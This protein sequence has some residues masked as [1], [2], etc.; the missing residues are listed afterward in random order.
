MAKFKLS[1]FLVR[2]RVIF[3]LAAVAI[4]IASI[5]MIPRTNI[6][7]D[8]TRYLPDDSQMKHGIDKMSEEFGDASL[9]SGMVRVMFKSLPDSTRTSIKDEL[10]DIEGVANVI[11]IEGSDEYNRDEM[12]L[13]ELL[14]NSKRSQHE[15]AD[16]ISSRYGDLVIVETSE[17]DTTA[18]IG[19]MLIAFALLLTVLLIMCESWLEPPIFLAAIGVAVAINMGTNALLE[20]VSATTNSIAAILQLVLSIDYS[21]ILMNRYRQE[22]TSGKGKI[23]AMSA[24]LNKASS[25]I[26]SSAFTTIVGLLALVFMKLKIGADMGIVLAKGV[27]CSLVAIFTVLPTL[28]I[29]LDGAIE[30]SRKRVI[31][32]HTERLAGFSMKFRIPLA[33]LFV[34]IFAGS[35]WLHTKTEI[36]FSIEQE[37][38]IAEFFPQKNITALLYSNSDS[39]KIIDLADSISKNPH[40]S[41]F[42]SYPSLM[43]KKYSA[44]ETK[45]LLDEMTSMTG[46]L[47]LDDISSEQ[48]V[49]TIYYIKSGQLAN[50]KISLHDFAMLMSDFATDTTYTTNIDI[51]IN[52][53]DTTMDI[54]QTLSLLASLTD[55]SFISQKMSYDEI[56]D[57]LGIDKEMISLICPP[58]AK[59]TIKE[60]IRTAKILASSSMQ[61]AH[62]RHRK[63]SPKETAVENITENTDNTDT[64]NNV[65][66]IAEGLH[67]NDDYNMYTDSTIVH[68]QYTT[69]E[70]SE[71]IGMKQAS[72]TLVYTLYGR[73]KG[74]KT[75]TMSIYEFIYFINHDLAKRRIFGSQLDDESREWLQN[76]E[77][78]MSTTLTAKQTQTAQTEDHS[79]PTPDTLAIVTEH[80]EH[81][82]EKHTPKP[83]FHAPKVD[84][85][86]L[87]MLDMAERLIDIATEAEKFGTLEM[88]EVLASFDADI[89]T[90]LLELA[91]LYYGTSNFNNDSLQM[92]AE[93]ILGIVTDSI[94]DNKKFAPMITE[95]IKTSILEANDMVDSNLGKLRGKNFS[96]AIIFSDYPKEAPETNDFVESL[97]AQCNSQLKGEHYLIGE[98]VMMNEMRNQFDSEMLLVTLI[99]ILSIFL[100]V[101]IT[102]RSLAVP[103]ILVM[104]VMSA[105]YINVY[106]SGLNGQLLYL[107]YLIMQSILMG[108][109]I[110]YGIL[111]TNNYREARTSLSVK[112]AIWEAYKSST[113]TIVTSGTIMTIA[114]LAMSFMMDDPTTI[115]IL[116]CIAIGAF[117]AVMLIIF[118]LPGLLGAFDRFIAKRKKTK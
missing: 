32:F 5:F 71:L 70:I 55:T 26:V 93:E 68:S 36:S 117:A 59:M 99:T 105:V 6:N 118:V 72:A 61:P 101:A 18:P 60:I 11:Y 76:T 79:A 83:T 9:G 89:D 63:E 27:L 90:S 24:A 3:M 78:L 44:Q 110:D 92:S 21:I 29:L 112:N 20:S 96:Q 56:S 14:G 8:M 114:P 43:Q 41:S 39:L 12:A 100:I 74:Q 75:K 33:I 57:I 22:K 37:S 116:Q 104:T 42:V 106:V 67:A 16:D 31:K 49:N 102:F 91:Y 62:H 52:S 48:I 77:E 103:F 30:K 86:M 46:D 28:I 82:E 98:S 69:A 73:T 51:P 111:F 38:E 23:E 58:G 88:H 4:A 84:P 35:Y 13:Y 80:K 95:N 19:V 85:E 94:I 45:G 53:P 34:A 17:Q 40:V 107:A 10:S 115:M 15:L 109:T 65:Q 87:K 108:A 97:T 66:D 81:V 7:S 1:D 113:H 54:E 47:N 25:S 50:E 64:T 2:K